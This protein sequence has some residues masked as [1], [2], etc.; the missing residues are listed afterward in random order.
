MTSWIA[1]GSNWS[2][3]SQAPIHYERKHLDDAGTAALVAEVRASVG[4]ATSASLDELTAALPGP[5]TSISLRAL[6]AKFPEDIA[7]LRRSPYEARADAGMYRQVL[8][9]LANERGWAVHFY[10]AKSVVQQAEAVLGDLGRE[11]LDGPR[12]VLAHRGPRTTGWRWPRRSSPA[13]RSKSG[14]PPGTR[15]RN[16]VIKSHLL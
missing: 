4:R 9:A 12:A 11:V 13:D 2:N 1:D 8:V 10:E 15:T 6:P 16:L 14:T 3:R 5:V 7:T